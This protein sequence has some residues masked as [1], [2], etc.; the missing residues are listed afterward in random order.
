MSTSTETKV[1]VVIQPEITKAVEAIVK[2]SNKMEGLN[3]KLSKTIRQVADRHGWEKDDARN[4]MI[5]SY[6]EVFQIPQ[7]EEILE[8]DSDTVKDAKRQ[9]NTQRANFLKS[10]GPDF[11]R[12]MLLAYPAP[13]DSLAFDP[14]DELNKAI[15]HNQKLGEG[16]LKGRIGLNRLYEIARGNVSYADTINPPAKPTTPAPTTPTPA[17]QPETPTPAETERGGDVAEQERQATAEVMQQEKQT[18]ITT[19]EKF[20]G[21]CA[22][23]K[24]QGLTLDE[25]L[26]AVHAV[27][28]Q[29]Q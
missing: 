7:H 25:A 19:Q 22:A 28:A 16:T 14:Q 1:T 10:R 8:G 12:V 15:E 26:K 13:K 24:L 29:Q 9:A 5:L 21:A 23:F 11:A 6:M 4:A 3:I 27:W 17:P 18:P 2:Q 20:E